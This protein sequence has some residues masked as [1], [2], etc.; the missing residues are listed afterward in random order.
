MNIPPRVFKTTKVAY[1]KTK[2]FAKTTQTLEPFEFDAEFHKPLRN[3]INKGKKMNI[4]QRALGVPTANVKNPVANVK[5][6]K[7]GK[8]TQKVNAR[9]YSPNS[10]FLKKPFFFSHPYFS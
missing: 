5:K 8:P 9:L 7:S 6:I 3:R 2:A 1:I 10:N 4:A